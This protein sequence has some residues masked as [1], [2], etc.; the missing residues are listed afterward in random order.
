MIAP[1]MI[2][3]TFSVTSLLGASSGARANLWAGRLG[4]DR[5]APR[6]VGPVGGKRAL[7]LP[8]RSL[9]RRRSPAISTRRAAAGLLRLALV[10]AFLELLE[11]RPQRSSELRE[12]VRAEQD[13]HDHQDHEQFLSSK[14]KHYCHSSAGDAVQVVLFPGP[15]LT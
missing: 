5:P 12:A 9:A 10:D 3:R 7:A 11:A 4:R 1:P 8:A 15:T 14:S 2:Q 13:Q 6:A